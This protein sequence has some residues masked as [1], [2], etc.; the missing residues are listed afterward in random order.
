[1]TKN[2]S[3]DIEKA[4][5]EMIRFHELN[6]E[7]YKND[8]SEYFDTK[9]A[10]AL[11]LLG[12]PDGQYDKILSEKFDVGDMSF[13][14]DKPKDEKFIERYAKNEIS[15]TTF[16]CLET[17][18]RAFISHSA[19]SGC[20]WKEYSKIGHKE[21]SEYLSK[22][23][24][25]NLCLFDNG[26]DNYQVIKR[27]FCGGGDFDD[28]GLKKLK[29]SNI[30]YCN[31]YIEYISYAAEYVS[32][33]G[34]YNTFKHGMYYSVN[35]KEISFVDDNNIGFEVKGDA[36]SY[37]SRKKGNAKEYEW[38]RV[39]KWTDHILD[40][41]LSL[42]YS[43]LLCELLTLWERILVIQNFES[44][45]FT[46]SLVPLDIIL[47]TQSATVDGLNTFSPK[48]SRKIE[49]HVPIPPLEVS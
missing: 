32:L 41:T 40:A 3:E 45:A 35:E 23:R 21:F 46:Q 4:K 15:M 8:V 22:L 31:R 47:K 28:D 43:G 16:H 26:L 24:V 11:H 33:N 36:I 44:K 42:V 1:M 37:I 30:E 20:P 17:F 5:M 14:L 6:R 9:I 18:L 49:I 48:L 12:N 38:Y 19:Y 27:V 25:G 7:F 13:T 29:V 10:L 39:V 2:N 34:E